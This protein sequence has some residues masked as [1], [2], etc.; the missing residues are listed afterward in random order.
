[1]DFMDEFLEYACSLSSLLRCR[2][3]LGIH[4]APLSTGLVWK[5]LCQQDLT[6]IL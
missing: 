5:I 1:M 3:I 2:N 4:L 6:A